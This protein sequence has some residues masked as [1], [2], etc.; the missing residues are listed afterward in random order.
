[1]LTSLRTLALAAFCLPLVLAAADANPAP[2]AKPIQGAWRAIDG[3]TE[4][5]MLVVDGYWTY[6]IFDRSTP[7]FHQTFGGP[8]REQGD[9]VMAA[10]DFNSNDASQVGGKFTAQVTVSGD[11]LT[12]FQE[13]GSAESWRRIDDA[14]SGLSGVWR[15]TGR[16]ADGDVRS[17]PL[18]ARRTY[19]VMTGTRFQWVAINIETG[20][21]SGTG[22]G[23][24]T[25]QDGK[26]VENIEFFSR[27][28]SRV[29]AKLQFEA[30]VKDGQWHHQGLSSRGEPIYEIWSKLS[31]DEG[32]ENLQR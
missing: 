32:R 24:Y 4:R 12:V 10:Y 23:T 8:Y 6:T 28:N 15:I 1:M 16:K 17:M 9:A 20:E 7:A 22:G 30:E 31:P 18:R 5:V 2:A 26:Y 14:T 13:D 19:K 25:Y 11:I 3:D 29:G 21:F 27:D